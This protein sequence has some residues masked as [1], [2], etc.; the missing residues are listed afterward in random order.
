MVFEKCVVKGC[1]RTSK[2]HRAT[3]FFSFPIVKD[4]DRESERRRM[5]WVQRTNT[6]EEEL[7]T[8]LSL[9]I[10]GRHFI[11]GNFHFFTMFDNNLTGDMS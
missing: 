11:L 2:T 7:M 8:K 5:V 6:T 4:I 1:G 3:S 10:C 9:K